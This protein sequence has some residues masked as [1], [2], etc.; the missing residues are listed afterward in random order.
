MNKPQ[1]SK[2]ML[3]EQLLFRV[4]QFFSFAF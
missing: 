2:A 1:I 3:E 4:N